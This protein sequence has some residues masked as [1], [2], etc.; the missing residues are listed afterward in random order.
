MDLIS[1]HIDSKDTIKIIVILSIGILF[2]FLPTMLAYFFNRKLFKVI[3]VACIP[4]VFS[5]IA[6]LGLLGWSLS[7][8]IVLPKKLREATNMIM[9]AKNHDTHCTEKSS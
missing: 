5:F 9:K 4:S 8:K 6:W 1:Q 2:W 7:N 3:L